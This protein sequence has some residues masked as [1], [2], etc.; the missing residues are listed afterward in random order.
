M[1]LIQ[2]PTLMEIIRWGLAGAVLVVFVF[3]LQ[4]KGERRWDDAEAL[5]NV[6]LILL[7]LWGLAWLLPLN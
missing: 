7:A 5:W 3:Y 4:A 6:D 1:P 2:H